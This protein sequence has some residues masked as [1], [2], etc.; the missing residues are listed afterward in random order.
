MSTAHPFT[1]AVIVII[2]IAFIGWLVWR[3]QKDEE[4]FD[5]D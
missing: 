1:I 2:A 5:K 4:N 3:N